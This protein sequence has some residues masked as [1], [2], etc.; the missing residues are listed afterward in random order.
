MSKQ[1][2]DFSVDHLST[3]FDVERRIY[4]ATKRL[5]QLPPPIKKILVYPTSLEVYTGPGQEA[6]AHDALLNWFTAAEVLERD[7]QTYIQLTIGGAALPVVF[8]SEQARE[9]PTALLPLWERIIY[10][11]GDKF[12]K[13][14]AAPQLNPEI[15]LHAFHSFKGG[16]GRTTALIS[17]A[18][19]YVQTTGKKVLLVDGDLEAPGITYW[20]T[21]SQRGAVSFSGFLE[22]LHSPPTDIGD[23]IDYFSK[24]ISKN[25]YNL[26]GN[27]VFILPAFVSTIDLLNSRVD[28]EH[29]ITLQD[30]R[31]LLGN[32]LHLLAEKL[33]ASAVFVDL[34]PGLSELSSPILFDARFKR[35]IVTTLA[36]QSIAGTELTLDLLMRAR[37]ALPDGADI[38]NPSIVLSLVT[39]QL[40]ESSI[41]VSAR[42]R[43]ET[44]YGISGT[45][46]NDESPS[47][48]SDLTYFESMFSAELMTLRDLDHAFRATR[49]STLFEAARIWFDTP[50]SSPLAATS[51]AL[52]EAAESLHRIT[53]ARIY[54]ES[55]VPQGL[56][57]TEALRNLGRAFLDESPNAVLIGAKGSGKTFNY[58]QIALSGTW[59]G[60]LGKLGLGNSNSP[61]TIIL[62]LLRSAELGPANLNAVRTEFERAQNSLLTATPSRTPLTFSEVND[63]LL[64]ELSKRS[65]HKPDWTNFWVDIISRAIGSPAQSLEQLNTA[66]MQTGA[67]VTCL[68]DGLEDTLKSVES[69]AVERTALEA[70]IDLPNRTRELRQPHIGIIAFVREDFARIAK[71]Q[72]FGQ[73]Q[74]R[75]EK[76]QLKWSPREFLQLVYWLCADA[77]IIGAT[78]SSV[79]AMSTDDLVEKLH[80]LWGKKLGR[81]VSAEAY[82]ARWVYSALC[83]LRGHLQARDVVRFL[84]IA[85]EQARGK[86]S[87]AWLD[88]VLPPAALRA[89]IP[90]TSRKKVQE[91]VE[92]YPALKNWRE[93][94]ALVSAEKKRIPLSADEV[95]LDGSL[96]QNLASIG[97]I[98]E[99]VEKTEPERLYVPEIY[100]EGLGIAAP[101]GA[102]PRVQALLQ[103]ALGKLP[104]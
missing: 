94:L 98:Y 38:Q 55:Q 46:A 28:P 7:G 97:V 73:F 58:L 59:Q 36:E 70:I 62:P 87:E 30:T 68:F 40:K 74:A 64:V 22:A 41:Y 31:W 11:T 69:D 82:S 56:L 9:R 25:I 33:G 44:A 24:E 86:R 35:T 37:R 12:P 47:L 6:L 85:A 34:R 103:R 54:A 83:D 78:K 89:A 48:R 65:T 75:Y 4:A 79:D 71:T 80:S 10:L 29:L 95:A 92:E 52:N 72:N 84:S 66:L 88:R 14:E 21:R 27:D 26:E 42:E 104:F 19:A 8:D 57:T 96:R 43:L 76:Y 45:E 5:T 101:A 99:D 102:R 18:A 61:R 67:Q 90:E 3:W 39:E 15:S 63:L 13:F 32:A 23:V 81:D 49:D 1:N 91:A 16:V 51:E 77:M 20:L 50:K 60:F 17:F 53:A 2:L 100:R 93:R